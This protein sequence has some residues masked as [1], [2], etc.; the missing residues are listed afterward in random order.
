VAARR[1]RTGERRRTQQ[2][3]KID[4]LI[5][6]MPELRQTLQKLKNSDGLTWQ[7]IEERSA[8][9]KAQGGF[10]EW[11]ELPT[12]VLEL[13]PD[14]RLPHSNLH[15]WYDL[16]VQ[17][18]VS[19]TLARSAQARE[20]AE[21]FARSTVDGSDEAVLNAARDQIMSILSEDATTKGRMGAAKAL[22]VLAEILQQR[23]TNELRERQVAVNEKKVQALLKREALTRRK[24]EA[25]TER[26]QKKASKGQVTE[27]DLARLKQRVF[28]IAPREESEG[29]HG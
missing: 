7:E 18:V 26:L 23:R 20:I 25:E 9:P 2:P 10:I 19:E 12:S 15:R 3:L 13:F 17:Q 16:R 24:L 29:A 28:G 6:A 27:A 14:M 22:I 11:D 8:L 4:R 21:A 5:E 1:P